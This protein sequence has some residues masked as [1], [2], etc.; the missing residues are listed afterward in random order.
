M[1]TLDIFIHLYGERERERERDC[2]DGVTSLLNLNRSTRIGKKSQP[3]K[4]F[5]MR[6]GGD[7]RPKNVHHGYLIL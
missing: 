2:S 7:G 6:F 4:S 3:M 1:S 5:V